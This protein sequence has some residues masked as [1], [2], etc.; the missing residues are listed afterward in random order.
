MRPKKTI[1][2]DGDIE[3]RLP[4]GA[5]HRIGG[6][7][8]IYGNGGFCSWWHNGYLHRTDGPACLWKVEWI[9]EKIKNGVDKR[10]YFP[11]GPQFNEG[12]LK[13][14]DD[15]CIWFEWWIDGKH[16]SFEEIEQI[17]NERRWLRKRSRMSLKEYVEYLFK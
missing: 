3:Y 16:L 14:Q 10:Y 6:P 8:A 1:D 13:D 9:K 2:A 11:S 12:L 7:A 17:K 15:K 5:L 4:D